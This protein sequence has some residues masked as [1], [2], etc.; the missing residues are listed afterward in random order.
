M[1]NLI[2][3][4]PL[5]QT[6]SDLRNAESIHDFKPYVSFTGFAF[7]IAV[8]CG[9]DKHL[10]LTSCLNAQNHKTCIRLPQTGWTAQKMALFI[11][12]Q[13][14]QTQVLAANAMAMP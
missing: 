2:L 13:Y 1:S 4:L 7:Y 5:S 14:R 8:R 10:Y 12:S 9:F 6:R 11:V 3:S